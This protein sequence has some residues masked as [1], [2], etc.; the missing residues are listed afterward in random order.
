MN[1]LSI[2][3]KYINRDFIKKV[4]GCLNPKNYEI[5]KPRVE[6]IKDLS[7]GV[8]LLKRPKE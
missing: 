7:V 4:L 3:G 2:I 1:K 8:C 5:I 6:D